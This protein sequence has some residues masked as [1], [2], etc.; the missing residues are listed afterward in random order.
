M[1]Y[2]GGSFGNAAMFGIPTG[3]KTNGATDEDIV[4]DDRWNYYWGGDRTDTTPGKTV[5]RNNG[6]VYWGIIDATREFWQT[7][8]AVVQSN[9]QASNF[10]YTHNDTVVYGF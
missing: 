10:T 4:T 8:L 3:I 5:S 9:L 7:D 6:Y 1:I 2:A